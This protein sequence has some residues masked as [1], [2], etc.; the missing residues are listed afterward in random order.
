MFF[1]LHVLTPHHVPHFSP[2][3]PPQVTFRLS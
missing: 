3:F 1:E 2:K